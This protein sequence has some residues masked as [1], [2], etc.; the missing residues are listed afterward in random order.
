MFL[1]LGEARTNIL[2]IHYLPYC[3]FC[4]LTKVSV[5]C[6]YLTGRTRR[7]QLEGLERQEGL[8][9]LG[10]QEGLEGLEGLKEQEVW[11]QENPRRQENFFLFL[12]IKNNKQYIFYKIVVV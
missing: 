4:E 3:P 2:I 11:K 6:I 8:E 9:G 5:Y 7:V 12:K 10:R 1:G